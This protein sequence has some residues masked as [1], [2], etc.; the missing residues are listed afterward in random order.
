M[1]FIEQWREQVSASL[2]EAAK[3]AVKVQGIDLEYALMAAGV[4]WPLRQPVQDFDMA[5]IAEVNK[6]LG[7]QAKHVL[8]TIQGWDNDLMQAAQALNTQVS[9][10]PELDAALNTLIKNFR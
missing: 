2:G 7:P 4:L 10:N 3:L 1:D 5:A 8:K 6:L 9:S